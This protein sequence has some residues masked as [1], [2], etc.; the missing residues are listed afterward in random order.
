MVNNF[1][2]FDVTDGG[3]FWQISLKWDWE[4]AHLFFAGF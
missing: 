1:D 4:T 2:E 3:G